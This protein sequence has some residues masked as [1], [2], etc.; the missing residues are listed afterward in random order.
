MS[1]R[2]P[3]SGAPLS[4]SPG[5]LARFLRP[6]YLLWSLLA[7]P[8]VGAMAGYW[9]GQLFYGEVIHLTGEWSV[10][11]LIVALAATPLVLLLPG[12]SVPRWLLSNR[13]YFGVA[14]FGYAALH[15]AVYAA[16]QGEWGSIAAE[17]IA[18]EYL[19]A[20]I[21]TGI[22]LLLA[23]TSNDASVRWMRQRWKTLHRFVY[24]AAALSF[25]HWL[26]VAFNPVPAVLHLLLLVALEAV[27]IWR[28]RRLRARRP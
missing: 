15:T 19:T 9:R 5:R 4:R 18:P 14:S 25:V 23:I 6:R 20:W 8:G 16:R 24:F 7:L 27:R 10:R 21:A 2:K 28:V 22:F 17:A 11:L 12:R 1:D 13:R 26:L 3:S